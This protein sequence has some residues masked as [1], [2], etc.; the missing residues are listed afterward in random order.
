VPHGRQDPNIKKECFSLIFKG[1]PATSLRQNSY[2]VE[3]DSLGKFRMLVVPVGNSK[4][5]L[6]EAVFNR[7][8]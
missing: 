6:Y 1:S 3:H 2:R 8:N 4:Q 5:N 7:L